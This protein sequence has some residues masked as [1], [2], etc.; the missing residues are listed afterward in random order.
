MTGM[1]ET[2]QRHERVLSLRVDSSDHS[3]NHWTEHTGGRCT[4]NMLNRRQWASL[5]ACH[6]WNGTRTLSSCISPDEIPFTDLSFSSRFCL[7][8]SLTFKLSS[9]LVTSSAHRQLTRSCKRSVARQCGHCWRW[10]VSHLYSTRTNKYSFH[11]RDL[12]RMQG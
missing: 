2:E 5:D 6:I 9:W 12:T 7:L 11:R 3:P 4:S 8:I 10:S 1:L